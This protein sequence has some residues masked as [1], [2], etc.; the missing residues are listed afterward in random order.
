V[1]NIIELS[2]LEM[3][4]INGGGLLEDIGYGV[5][6]AECAIKQANH[7]VVDAVSTWFD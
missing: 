6:A 1:K 3:V 7:K 2:H 5:H 4:T